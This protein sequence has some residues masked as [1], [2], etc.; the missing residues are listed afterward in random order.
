[1]ADAHQRGW[2]R[3]VAAV[4]AVL[5]LL[6]D[7]VASQAATLAYP[8]G[9]PLTT[10]EAGATTQISVVLT[11]AP[12]AN[13][14]FGVSSS[15]PGEG[16]AAAA[17]L[18]FTTANWNVP[19]IVT[20][21]GQQDAVDDGNIAY[22]VVFAAAVSTD[23]AY[24]GHKI[25]DQPVTNTDDD[26]SA[27][28]VS[29]ATLSTSELATTAT[30]TIVLATQPVSNV[31]VTVVST[32]LTENTVSPATI[33]FTAGVTG[34]GANHWSTPQTV[35][36]TGV[37]DLVQD[38]DQ[39][40][41]IT[42]T[43]T[44]GD[45]KYLA[46]AATT[47]AVT[48]IDNDSAGVT[49]TPTAGLT[50]TEAG[51]TTQFSV[52]LNTMPAGV[53]TIAIANGNA[54]EGQALPTSLTFSTTTWNVPQLVTVTGQQDAIQDGNTAYTVTT[55][56][57]SPADA[58]YNAKFGQTIQLLNM[59]DDTAGFTVTP[60]TGLQ[61][62]ELLA[63]AQFSIVLLAQPAANVL[64]DSVSS[65]A[66]EGT[67]APAQLTFTNANW[68]T[69]QVVTVTGVNDFTADGDIPYTIL[70][71]VNAAT[72][73]TNYQP[74]NP[75]DVAVLNI[76]NDVP[77][78]VVAPN[79]IVT[80]ETTGV[81]PATFTVVLATQPT[82]DVTIQ[83][84][85][86]DQEAKADKTE[87]VFTTANWN[88]AQT[89]TMTGVDDAID[90]GN[91][92]YTV[93]ASVKPGGTTDTKY[94][95][96][97]PATLTGTNLDDDTA[98]I[99]VT[100]VGGLVTTEI[101][102]SATFTVTL[103]T[104]PTADV[105]IGVASGDT[106]EATIDKSSLVFTAATY[107][108]PQTVTVTG[109]QDAIDDGDVAYS[110]T[111]NA[112]VS[113][114][115]KYSG[116]HV[117]QKVDG[118]N[119]DDDTAGVQVTPTSGLVVTEAGGTA[120]FSIELFTQPTATVTIAL[121]S[122][123]TTEGT[124]SPAS[125]TFT[126]GAAGPGS[127]HW[128]TAIPVT[129]T[130]V[131]DSVADGDIVFSIVTAQAT[132]TDPKYSVMNPSDV[133]VTCT[134]DDV[135]GV[136]VTAATGLTTREDGSK[137]TFS[138]RLRSEPTNAVTV[139]MTVDVTGEIVVS[140]TPL[141]FT[142]ANWMTDQLVTLTGQDDFKDDGDVAFAVTLT[143]VS[144]DTKYA[145]LTIAPVTG[146][147]IDNDVPGVTITTNA[148]KT[149][150]ATSE[151][152]TN[153]FFDVQLKTLPAANVVVT[154]VSSDLTEGSP[155]PAA[156]TFTAANWN[157]AQRVT[158]Q[159]ADD[160]I[161]DGVQP[162]AISVQSVVSTDASYS[163]LAVTQIVNVDNADDD[164]AR[165]LACPSPG[166]CTAATQ[167]GATVLA[168][169]EAGATA[170]FLVAL[171]TQPS[172]GKKVYLDV[173]VG[174]HTEGTVDKT[175]LTFD[176]TTWNVPQEVTITGKQDSI[177]DGT[178]RYSIYLEPDRTPTDADTYYAALPHTIVR[179]DNTDDDTKTITVTPVTPVPY[180]TT[181]KGG[182]AEFTV[183]LGS[184]PTADVTIH[185]LS[186][187]SA[188]GTV[189]TAR[190]DF[191]PG[192]WNSPQTVRVTGVQ[193]PIDDGDTAYT[194]DMR[195]ES[196]DTVYHAHPITSVALTNTDDDDA[197]VIVSPTTGL[198]TSEDGT[199]ATF[200]VVLQTQ[201][202]A[203]V[204]I[205]LTVTPLTEVSLNAAQ[206]V[207][208]TGGPS[209]WSKPQIVTVTGLDD[210]IVDGAVTYTITTAP[211]VST[212]A[213]YQGMNAAD[214]TG[215][216]ADN[217]V[218]GVVLAPVSGVWNTIVDEAGTI[219]AKFT[220]KLATQPTSVVV[221]KFTSSDLLSGVIVPPD[222]FTF[223]AATWNTPQTAT[224]KGVDDE[225]DDG[226]VSFTVRGTA[227]TVDPIYN[228]FVT[229]PVTI[230]NRDDDTAG[231][232]L[233]KTSVTTTEGLPDETVNVKLASKPLA[234]VSITFTVNNVKQGTIMPATLTLNDMNWKAG[235][236]VTIKS[237][238]DNVQDGDVTYTIATS[239]TTSTDPKYSGLTIQDITV[240]D[241]DNDKAAIV[242]VPD[243]DPTKIF[244]TEDGATTVTIGV[245]LGSEPTS[246]V[247]VT[248]ATSDHTE[249]ILNPTVLT[250]TPT[251][252]GVKNIVVTGRDDQI[253]DGNVPFLVSVLQVT[254]TD[255]MYSSIP[256]PPPIRLTNNDNDVPAVRFYE[257]TGMTALNPLAFQRTQTPLVTKEAGQNVVF[258]VKLATQPNSNVDL[259]ITSIDTSEGAVT[260]QRVTLTPGSWDANTRVEIRGLQDAV[261]DGDVT[262]EI[263]FALSTT[264]TTG[265]AA[266]TVPSV[267]IKNIDDDTVGVSVTPTSGLVTTEGLLSSAQQF[268]IVLHTEP[269]ADVTIDIES[270]DTTEGMVSPVRLIFVA[271]SCASQPPPC[272]SGRTQWSVPQLVTVTPVDD[273][274][275]DGD[276]TYN[277]RV[278]KPVT[279]DAEYAVQPEVMVAVTNKDND[280]AGL[281][282][283]PVGPIGN[284][285]EVTGGPRTMVKYNVKLATKP[286]ADVTVA[287][288]SKDTTEGTVTP[289]QFVFTPALYD[290][291]QEFTIFG[292]D[293]AVVDGPVSFTIDFATTS[294]DTKYGTLL[295]VP[296]VPVVNEDNDVP[297]IVVKDKNKVVV[298]YS[299][300][301]SGAY[302]LTTQENGTPE[303]FYVSL[304]SE[305]T[306]EVKLL[307]ETDNTA[308]GQVSLPTV[309]FTAANWNVDQEVKITGVDEPDPVQD[310]TKLY[311]VVFK[312]ALSLDPKYAGVLV[313]SI[314][315]K[316]LDDDTVG[317]VLNP[318][319]T[320]LT[321]TEAAGGGRTA[322]FT[323]KLA[324][325]PLSNVAIPVLTGDSTE[326]TVS[327]RILH[328]SPT[329]YST[330]AT[331]V[332]TGADDM[333]DDGDTTY[334]VSLGA[335]QSADPAYNGYVSPT[336]RVQVRNTDDDT[337]GGQVCV[338]PG[339][340][341]CSGVIE[342]NAA[343]GST[344]N[345]L[346]FTVALSTQ[347]LSDV[348]IPLHSNDTSEGVVSVS[349]VRF[350]PGS[351]SFPQ[352]VTVTGVQDSVDDGDVPFRIVLSP[353][354]SADPRFSGL[355]LN[356]V[357]LVAKDDDTFGI[358]IQPK[359]LTIQEK[360]GVPGHS[361]EFTVVLLTQPLHD[362]TVEL[363]STDLT[364]GTLDTS[365]LIF[366]PNIQPSTGKI[367]W[368]TPQR[369]TVTAVD[370][371]D[372]DGDVTFQVTMAPATSLDPRYNG[373]RGPSLA[374]T[375]VNDEVC[376]LV[377]V[378]RPA[379]GSKGC[380]AT[381]M[382]PIG[383][384]C[385]L[386]D[387]TTGLV[388]T[389]T[390]CLASGAW[391]IP[392][393]TCG[394][395]AVPG[396][397][398]TPAPGHA[399][400]AFASS[401]V[402]KS[403]A[404]LLD[405]STTACTNVAC[406][407]NCALFTCTVGVRNPAALCGTGGC[408]APACCTT[409]PTTPVPGQTT[410]VGTAGD[411]DLPNWAIMLIILGVLFL[412]ASCAALLWALLRKP[413]KE[414][415][416][417]EPP[418]KSVYEGHDST[419]MQDRQLREEGG[420]RYVA[421]W[422]G[423]KN[424]YYYAE[425]G[426]GGAAKTMWH[427]P[428]GGYVVSWK[429]G[430]EDAG[431]YSA[432][433]SNGPAAPATYTG[434]KDP[435]AVTPL[436]TVYSGGR[437]NPLE[438]LDNP[439]Y[440]S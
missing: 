74:L 158:A 59:D 56:T 185:V 6:C 280:V 377:H 403:N 312:P 240:L 128:S 252:Y 296:P 80:S 163:G 182:F 293:D 180:T 151:P 187:N 439:Q 40:H 413:G 108:S 116:M 329:N 309:T 345:T 339:C 316:N 415:A 367:H 362:V 209:Q 366:T 25:N 360:A 169:T 175:R 222:S 282:V 295:V 262:Y 68:N 258:L 125:V 265:Y 272:A 64:I 24:N 343:A 402:L 335:A 18:T 155:N 430:P 321:T 98:G 426:A 83:I 352:T 124:V 166:A 220:A 393:P 5:L 301:N 236:P 399:C 39:T 88:T 273:V 90:D 425:E 259:T 305:P 76:D 275:A 229:M 344:K 251:A 82:A 211:A 285:R 271:H 298:P 330:P 320:L 418:R 224:V 311:R 269:T 110:I 400:N 190:L 338:L 333:V 392:E 154:F 257:E 375:T 103:V 408:D 123:D 79:A 260:Q 325:K 299:R 428:A 35:T 19:Q 388:C 353:A 386:I 95:A 177:D 111:I 431:G 303:L 291:T 267:F 33:T 406:C 78:I 144:A 69:A 184:Q 171:A 225:I 422:S 289:A 419:E 239:Q 249:A 369:V 131:Q 331:V 118:T 167:L 317:L 172:V 4:T 266:L 385:E 233:D 304:L 308:E 135:A 405:C 22:N 9:L 223:T 234:P 133:S 206:L 122:D 356:D 340:T 84:T 230:I 203:D 115:P 276:I 112:A 157:V 199:T 89:I 204:T 423:T 168:T 54:A 32:D 126:P 200:S 208:T 246:T 47:V 228:G 250:F 381:G 395:T 197:L 389:P 255:A 29:T 351:W 45:A 7:G 192:S 150:L 140:P 307:I 114:D 67:A 232:I 231:V 294:T 371:T 16:L 410:V 397:S 178:V 170:K 106:S 227:T 401:C 104:Q 130:G 147:N 216:N 254:T 50:T 440:Q 334:M 27:L 396:T 37:D 379:G 370:D 46:L 93:I 41:T 138:V 387:T 226:D 57:A 1:M 142:S 186:S 70:N 38:G 374:V 380:A 302:S 361:A 2:L 21:T 337:S 183:T 100:P 263:R 96:V 113:T 132:T 194:V 324:T 363:T 253:A 148:M 107:G 270:L 173:N 318:A 245:R 58:N 358:D 384:V 117:V 244:T 306:N 357:E 278:K 213:S 215:Q 91:I 94:Q 214:V 347:P 30:Y 417:E 382:V 376:N 146:V 11:Q 341:C 165:I 350:T 85:S 101:G 314:S 149:R 63:T 8:S 28:V 152:S 181:E 66:T 235:L 268:S 120:T 348:V 315:A 48:N 202:R 326:G 176:E 243:P 355:D 368:S 297:G 212:D 420:D 429:G 87:V 13:V 62:S 416:A 300:I 277:V 119:T 201:P 383:A 174:D 241:K 354:L 134:D 328:F 36:V 53:V 322:S 436:P 274:M 437:H 145:G 256:Y 292:E 121:S 412:L 237:V 391:S 373:Y 332:V 23:L 141:T 193:D 49:I 323:V 281:V 218:A 438:S 283:T 261:Q 359:M 319:N 288:T 73:D 42:N 221:L 77:A 238:D 286:V 364:E 71:T 207:F 372:G 242:L 290:T 411:D 327:P 14:V 404:G 99:T 10:T 127:N 92:V 191:T 160:N 81:P 196:T 346:S 43:V 109:V 179:V 164:V 161:Q 342:E 378:A 421:R 159:A 17:S 217:D 188:E 365:R 284:L 75:A 156:L 97:Q 20:V 189:S 52:V 205:G 195:A 210:K 264:D 247:T 279:T 86:T 287:I 313:P 414:Q 394:L 349:Q 336:A 139:A 3:Q 72:A 129:V 44:T 409:A 424:R 137:A 198:M 15:D 219:E 61:T 162:Y 434:V 248:L 153:D 432:M 55:T 65:D 102:G 31:I 390:T 34:A 105:T 60:T 398:G 433:Q 51:G 427:L 136:I 310:G 26:T 143:T 407:V 435:Y 12:T